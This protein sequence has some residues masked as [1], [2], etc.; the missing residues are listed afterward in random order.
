MRRLF[1][2]LPLGYGKEVPSR[3]TQDSFIRECPWLDTIVPSD[4]NIPYDMKHVNN[5][6]YY[7]LSNFNYF[8]M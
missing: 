6:N 1:D 8:Q 5:I 2:F 7:V 4:P 3:T